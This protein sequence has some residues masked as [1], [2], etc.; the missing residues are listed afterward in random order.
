MIWIPFFLQKPYQPEG[1]HRPCGLSLAV[2][3][4]LFR[5][6][7]LLGGGDRGSIPLR[8]H[9]LGHVLPKHSFLITFDIEHPFLEYSILMT[10]QTQV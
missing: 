6:G 7:K 1:E 3:T 8:A 5:A 2:M 4:S 9:M 10:L